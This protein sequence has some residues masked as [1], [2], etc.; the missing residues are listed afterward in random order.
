MK[1]IPETL[2]ELETLPD[3]VLTCTQVSK[4]LKACPQY[5]HAQAIQDPTKLG[6]PVIVHGTRVKIPKQ[7]FVRYMRGEKT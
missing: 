3:E 4:I 6:F 2:A 7:A 1:R 5:I